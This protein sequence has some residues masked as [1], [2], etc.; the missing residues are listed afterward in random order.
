[1]TSNTEIRTQQKT[2]AKPATKTVVG[3]DES[4]ATSTAL[5]AGSPESAT[6]TG[7]LDCQSTDDSLVTAF[8]PVLRRSLRSRTLPTELVDWDVLGGSFDR[9]DP[10]DRSSHDNE[11]IWNSYDSGDFSMVNCMTDGG[12]RTRH[13]SVEDAETDAMGA[14]RGHITDQRSVSFRLDEMEE[15]LILNPSTN[16]ADSAIGDTLHR[17]ALETDVQSA[18][19]NVV[20]YSLSGDLLGNVLRT[21]KN[22]RRIKARTSPCMSR[23]EQSL[24]LRVRSCNAV[25]TTY[26]FLLYLFRN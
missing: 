26:G 18:N 13:G 21:T 4:L 17:L 6:T 12:S 14:V 19:S 20:D 15:D 1:M 22:T 2:A 9:C 23:V 16:K 25:T 8:D 11:S 10:W 5:C 7:R 3:A 24:L